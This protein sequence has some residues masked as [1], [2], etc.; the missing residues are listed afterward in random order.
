MKI[1]YDYQQD[2]YILARHRYIYK[3]LAK[4]IKRIIKITENNLEHEH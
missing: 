4:M 1:F 3:E 2:S